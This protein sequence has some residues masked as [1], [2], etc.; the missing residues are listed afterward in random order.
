MKKCTKC[1]VTKA[2]TE[3]YS[4]QSKPGVFKYQAW[5]KMC[6]KAHQSLSRTEKLGGRIRAS[7]YLDDPRDDTLHLQVA[8]LVEVPRRYRP[9]TTDQADHCLFDMC[10]QP[11]VPPE[12]V[13][14]TGKEVKT[15]LCCSHWIVVERQLFI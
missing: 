12:T 10:V 4:W 9:Y 1:L 8:Q 7:K 3:F 5:C 6:M 15:F 14:V 11:Y 13:L 2:L